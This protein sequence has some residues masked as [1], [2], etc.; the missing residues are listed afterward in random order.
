MNWFKYFKK[1]GRAY[2][3][4]DFIYWEYK[5]NFPFY[6]YHT[7][8]QFQMFP[9]GFE[10]QIKGIGVKPFEIRCSILANYG[11]GE[12]I[13][14]GIYIDKFIYNSMKDDKKANW[15]KV[16]PKEEINEIL[17]QHQIE[18][19]SHFIKNIFEKPQE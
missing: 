4:R 8:I 12:N 13:A 5:L 1:K 10:H 2:E 15:W 14:T 3:W 11:D 17:T 16:F 7:A 9:K 19:C 6:K 18:I